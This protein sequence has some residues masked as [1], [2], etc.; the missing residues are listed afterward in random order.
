RPPLRLWRAGLRRRGLAL[1][2]ADPCE[3]RLERT[4]RLAQA[5]PGVGNQR[6]GQAE[7]LG[8][9]EGLRAAGQPDREVVRGAERLEIELDRGVHRAPGGVRVRL[10]LGVV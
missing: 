8:D 5:G 7:S 3:R 10:Q 4:L 1:G 2:L 9:G 6:L